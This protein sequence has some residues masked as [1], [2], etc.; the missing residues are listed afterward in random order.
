MCFVSCGPDQLPQ[1]SSPLEIH[2]IGPWAELYRGKDA[3][4]AGLSQQSVE[5]RG[6]VDSERITVRLKWAGGI[7]SEV[8]RFTPENAKVSITA[9]DSEGADARWFE[10]PET[11]ETSCWSHV[12]KLSCRDG[13]L[14]TFG[15][16]S[17]DLAGDY[18]VEVRGFRDP[19]FVLIVSADGPVVSPFMPFWG[20]VRYQGQSYQ[21]IYD[22]VER[23]LVAPAVGLPFRWDGLWL[24]CPSPDDRLVLYFRQGPEPRLVFAPTGVR[25]GG[26]DREKALDQ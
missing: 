6:D 15:G 24:S 16:P 18:C 17:V 5:F 10:L 11:S 21:Q 22:L 23:E 1:I 19:R 14:S 7:A 26:E 25:G 2:S 4:I 12:R 8:V 3:P 9:S 13:A 20:S